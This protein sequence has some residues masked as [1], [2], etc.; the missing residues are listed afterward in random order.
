MVFFCNIT[1]N[2]LSKFMLKH[3]KEDPSGILSS[4]HFTNYLSAQL[5]QK[6]EIKPWTHNKPINNCQLRFFC[7]SCRCLSKI[8]FIRK[9]NSITVK[10][11][12]IF[13]KCRYNWKIKQITMLLYLSLQEFVKEY[14]RSFLLFLGDIG[15][16]GS[17]LGTHRSWTSHD[18][19]R[20]FVNT[21]FLTDRPRF[22]SSHH[23]AKNINWNALLS[24]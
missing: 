20:N 22:E 9:V 1:N 14:F 3:E 19:N 5:M 6:T 13:D 17:N 8:I 16:F 23:K 18:W 2:C 21:L 10:K 12:T 24:F 11:N 7:S 15:H 4:E